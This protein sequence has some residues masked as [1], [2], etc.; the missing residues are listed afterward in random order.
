MALTEAEELE[1]LEL[2]AAEAQAGGQTPPSAEAAQPQ[3]KLDKAAQFSKKVTDLLS[4][5]LQP[6]GAAMGAVEKGSEDLSNKLAESGHPILAM[7][8]AGPE[9]VMKGIQK[10]FDWL[11]KAGEK[12]AE[13]G[14]E[15]GVPPEIAAGAGTLVQMAPD[16][17]M[18]AEGIAKRAML[19]NLAKGAA[20]KAGSVVTKPFSAAKELITAPAPADVLSENVAK[21]SELQSEREAAR[22]AAKEAKFGTDEAI[23]TAKMEGA[24]QLRNARKASQAAKKSLISAEEKAGVHMGS[25][26][27][28]EGMI[29]DPKEMMRFIESKYPIVK[30]GAQQ[31]AQTVDSQSLQTLRKIAQEAEK[32]AL[33]PLSEGGLGLSDIAKSQLKEIKSTVTDA[34]G[35]KEP[36]VGASLGKF[37]AAEEEAKAIP[38]RIRQAIE[39]KKLEL[40][41]GQIK[42]AKELSDIEQQLI[43]QRAEGSAELSKA[44]KAALKKKLIKAG[45]MAAGTY[46][47]VRSI[48]R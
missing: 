3:S 28:F 12:I 13:K 43:K 33:K 35:I 42:K 48:F 46:F 44:K 22:L 11:D 24:E 9:I 19:A 5:P 16:I 30:Q 39:K 7:H 41:Q 37:R 17:A 40:T 23:K 45:L 25:T 26:P 34:L 8:A 18:G 27:E 2:E 14:G 31:L 29:K 36:E 10:P 1:L 38:D 6:I 32:N 4:K 21:M 47:G 20:E 15:I